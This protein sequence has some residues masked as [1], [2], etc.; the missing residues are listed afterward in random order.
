MSS[1]ALQEWSR[2][3]NA[4]AQEQQRSVN[5]IPDRMPTLESCEDMMVH[6]GKIL[7][8]LQRMKEIIQQQEHAL[9][10]QRMREQGG[11]VPGEYDDD[12]SMYGDDMKN[13]GFG[14]SDGKKRRGVCSH[15]LDSRYRSSDANTEGS[16]T[17]S[18]SQ[19]QQGGDS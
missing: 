5:V 12:M 17:R 3:Y 2:H 16:P 15:S 8:A 14:A 13:Q 9:M 7:F 11:R 6:Q 4:I 1:S 18:M 10:D 19:L